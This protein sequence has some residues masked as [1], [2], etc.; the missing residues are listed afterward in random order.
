MSLVAIIPVF[1]SKWV[2]LTYVPFLLGRS[3]LNMT[4]PSMTCCLAI[5][6][7]IKLKNIIIDFNLSTLI[8][9]YILDESQAAST[10]L[11]GP[12]NRYTPS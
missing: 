9:A 1:Y 11:S 5:G 7:S 2:L 3:I 8:N 10:I 4:V 6:L 12:D